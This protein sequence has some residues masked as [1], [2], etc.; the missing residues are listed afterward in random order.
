MKNAR[1]WIIL[2]VVFAVAV[3]LV[4]ELKHNA[5]QQTASPPLTEAVLAQPTAVAAPSPTPVGQCAYVWAYQ[6]I[7]TLTDELTT[8]LRS[9]IPSAEALVQAFGEDCVYEDGQKVFTPLETDFYVRLHVTDLKDEEALGNWILQI[10]PRVLRLRAD[11]IQGPQLGFVEF[12]FIQSET[13]K[14]IVRVP[15]QQFREQGVGK[16]G[17]ELFRLFYTPIVAPT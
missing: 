8:S 9:F 1:N 12:T 15:I 7:P 13:E 16:S 2:L 11:Q 6:D 4:I 3:T 14:I 10:I 17:K 5:A